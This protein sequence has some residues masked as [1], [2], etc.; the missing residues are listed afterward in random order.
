M[1]AGLRT[2]IASSSGSDLSTSTVLSVLGQGHLSG[3]AIEW[4]GLQMLNA[5]EPLV[6]FNRRRAISGLIKRFKDVHGQDRAKWMFKRERKINRTVEDLLELTK[7]YLNF[8]GFF[9]LTE[10]FCRGQY[11]AHY[12]T[13]AIAQGNLLRDLFPE[14]IRIFGSKESAYLI[15]TST[16]L[17]PM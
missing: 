4:V 14:S 11:K 3:K 7:S 5:V 6:I 17:F 8:P 9:M 10:Y 12:R 16:M 1:R 15:S 13:K 2:S